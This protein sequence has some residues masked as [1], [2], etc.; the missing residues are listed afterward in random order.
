LQI[1]VLPGDES[2]E[3][4]WY[5]ELLPKDEVPKDEVPKEKAPHLSNVMDMSPEV[6]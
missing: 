4:D 5:P 2:D 1:I 6:C 3:D